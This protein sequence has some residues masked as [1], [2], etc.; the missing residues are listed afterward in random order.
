MYSQ[1]LFILCRTL[2]SKRLKRLLLSLLLCTRPLYFLSTNIS[3]NL[4]FIDR[5]I[6]WEQKKYHFLLKKRVVYNFEKKIAFH[7]TKPEK[8]HV[9]CPKINPIVDK[10]RKNNMKHKK[11]PEKMTFVY[12]TQNKFRFCRQTSIYRSTLCQINMNGTAFLIHFI[13]HWL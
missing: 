3:K 1:T 10:H 2:Y 9:E 12:K 5:S 11:M 4:R 13:I 8:C 6:V 7:M